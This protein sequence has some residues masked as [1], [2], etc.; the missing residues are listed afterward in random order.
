MGPSSP[1]PRR[2]SGTRII[3]AKPPL[4]QPQ[5]TRGILTAA[6]GTI[7]ESNEVDIDR[8]IDK[9]S[10]SE[11]IDRLPYRK[12]KSI[13]R[14]AVVWI[15]RAAAMEPFFQDQAQIVDALLRTVGEAR[16]EV[17]EC[18]GV[19][20][21]ALE[22]PPRVPHLVLSDLGIRKVEGARR[23]STPAGW[24]SLGVRVREVLGADMVVLTPSSVH[25][26]SPEVKAALTIVT[27]DRATSV[28]S[29]SRARLAT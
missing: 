7:G 18:Q 21:E 16:L 25:R 26:Y 8:L 17:R 10:R 2:S 5:W 9:M 28:R 12:V 29:L 14:G 13:S 1:V 3:P 4:L 19:P 24:A 20:Y 6:L 15:D 11:F 23:T 27:W 22:Q